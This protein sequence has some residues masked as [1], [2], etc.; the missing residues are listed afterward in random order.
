[1]KSLKEIFL[2]KIHGE[3][4]DLTEMATSRQF[5]SGAWKSSDAKQMVKD[6]KNGKETYEFKNGD[7]YKFVKSVASNKLEKGMVV[8][9][10]YNSSNQ[11]A[12]IYEIKGFT[13]S[14]EKYGESGVK[15][16]SINDV[17]KANKV[18][19]LKALMDLE[20]KNEY[21]RHTYMVIKDLEDQSEGAWFYLYKGS[22]VRG[23]GAEKLTF[24]IVTKV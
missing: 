18:T 16:D 17:F 1:M 8:M 19:S 20:D 5:T 24:Y 10:S 3:N 4:V 23:S 2:E 9:A 15:F 21:G 22:W 14:V 11:G 12:Q 6:F 7:T 13:D